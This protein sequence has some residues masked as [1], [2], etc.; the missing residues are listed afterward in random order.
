LRTVKTDAHG[1]FKLGLLEPGSY[2]VKITY[3]GFRE[4][5][6]E[7]LTLSSNQ[8]LRFDVMLNVG[9]AVM[10]V[11]VCEEPP[12]KGIIIDGVR[13]SINED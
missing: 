3:P 1:Q 13:V 12:S 4:F 8:D 9:S 6:R 2:T 7:H 10:G 5:Q 11:L